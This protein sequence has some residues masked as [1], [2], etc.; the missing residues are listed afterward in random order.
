MLLVPDLKGRWKITGHGISLDPDGNVLDGQHRLMA[1]IA[2]GFPVETIVV[3]GIEPGA[4]QYMDTGR[5]RKISDILKMFDGV[6][7]A[8]RTVATVRFL[9]VFDRGFLQ[10]GNLDDCREV[11]KE[12]KKQFEWISGVKPGQAPR[13][14]LFYAPLVW[15]HR[16]G[17]PDEAE[18]FLQEMS[19]LEGLSAGSPVLALKHILDNRKLKDSGGYRS[20]DIALLTFNALHAYVEGK[21]VKPRNIHM[22]TVGFD[23]F[24]RE[25]TGLGRRRRGKSS[26]EYSRPCSFDK[27]SKTGGVSAG[28]CWLHL[29]Y[30]N[31]RN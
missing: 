1:I 16:N 28:L 10:P 14:A 19:T 27:M 13:T 7:N 23:F 15:A 2:Y 29:H 8:G 12:Y 5:S 3:I 11:I 25:M 20:L 4:Q 22:S 9:N 6:K 31:M 18:M 21:K 17:L 30:G 24:K 26:C